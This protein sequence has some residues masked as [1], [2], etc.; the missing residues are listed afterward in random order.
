MDQPQPNHHPHL[1]PHSHHH[2][3]PIL[4]HPR[5]SNRSLKNGNGHSSNAR[6]TD[7]SNRNAPREQSRGTSTVLNEP[8]SAPLLRQLLRQSNHPNLERNWP[9]RAKVVVVAES[10]HI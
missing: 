8:I 4:P 2:P 7:H 9:G 10:N 3:P 5:Q 6:R 1:G